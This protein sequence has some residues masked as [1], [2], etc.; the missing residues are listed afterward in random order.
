MLM[1]VLSPCSA[2]T[3][4]PCCSLVPFHSKIFLTTKIPEKAC[5]KFCS[6]RFTFPKWTT[7][8]AKGRKTSHGTFEGAV[9][10]EAGSSEDEANVLVDADGRP[11]AAGAAVRDVARG[12]GA[13]SGYD[14]FYDSDKTWRSVEIESGVGAAQESVNGQY[15]ER[16]TGE[17]EKADLESEAGDYW[18]EFDAREGKNGGAVST[19]VIER[20]TESREEANARF[21]VRNGREVCFLT[22]SSHRPQII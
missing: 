6:S 20:T 3:S 22:R 4:G 5:R 2:S 12:Y 10:D 14:G 21:R 18:G 7:R 11:G 16:G 8:A 19:T 17:R 9:V 1:P 15:A 13:E